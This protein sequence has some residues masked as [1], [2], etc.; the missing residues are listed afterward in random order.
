MLLFYFIIFAFTVIITVIITRAKIEKDCVGEMM[1]Y[2]GE[3]GSPE[4]IFLVS[5][6]KQ[7]DIKPGNVVKV[8][9]TKGAIK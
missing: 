9:I 5:E 7:N 1:I 6:G 8:M 4:M 3:D 2:D